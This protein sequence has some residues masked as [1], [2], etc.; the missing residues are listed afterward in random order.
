MTW[1]E[2]NDLFRKHT[3]FLISSHLSLDGD[4]VGSQLALGWYL[5][6]L[7]K[8]VTVFDVD[9]VPHKFA[10]LADAGLI[11]HEKPRRAFDVLVI[12]DC[13]NLDRMGWNGCREIAPVMVNIDHHRDNTSFAPHNIVN[14]HAAATA[15]LLYR[16][17]AD[18]RVHYP[19]EVAEALYA[20]ILTD[21]GGFRF[22]ITTSEI[23][24][25]CA[26]LADRNIDCAS[27][28]Q[29]SYDSHTPQGLLLWSRIWSTL[30][31]H[32]DG[33][34]CTIELPLAVID[35]LGASRSDCEGMADYTIMAQ[36]VMVGMFIKYR[37]NETHFSLRSR[38]SVD[39]GKIAHSVAGGGG[40]S[41]AAGCTIKM[42]FAAARAM[43]LEL[44][45]KELG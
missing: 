15:E 8:E 27:I 29:H 24:R 11:V 41:G 28:Y 38:G 25:M 4:S 10:F 23:F 34:V 40:H 43:M 14:E 20:A 21:T 12:L 3:S 37:D 19:R 22:S 31:F 16:F 30:Q 39:V 9:P 18:Q 42:P 6:S 5:R 44:L 32:L 26:D 1:S 7:G 2:L 36:G 33:R 13:S 17:F 45:R 35:E